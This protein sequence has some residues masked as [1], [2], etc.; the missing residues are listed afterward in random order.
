[1]TTATP[2]KLEIKPDGW[3]R[4]G[5]R[6]EIQ[7]EDSVMVDKTKDFVSAVPV[8]I[9]PTQDYQALIDWVRDAKAYIGSGGANRGSVYVGHLLARLEQLNLPKTEE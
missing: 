8:S 1:M 7:D 5:W 4:P 6:Q 3:I 2:K 9:I